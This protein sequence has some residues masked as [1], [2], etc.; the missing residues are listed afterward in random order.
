MKPMSREVIENKPERLVTF[1]VDEE[2]ELRM[3]NQMYEVS[4]RN[5][6]ED[7]EKIER[8]VAEIGGLMET[9][10]TYL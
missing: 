10:R 4:L 5:K 7:A 1:T 8:Q 6:K 2:T 3:E 9:V